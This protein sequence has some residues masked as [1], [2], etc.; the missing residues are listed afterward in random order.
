ML[1]F[2]ALQLSPDRDPLDP[3]AD[4]S[5]DL[6][7]RSPNAARTEAESS[8]NVN[9]RSLSASGW[10]RNLPQKLLDQPPRI[11]ARSPVERAAL[12]YLHANCGHCHG[13]SSDS[14]GAVPVEMLLAQDVTD[15]DS[16]NKV[17][18]SLIGKQS[19]FRMAAADGT[20]SQ[21]AMPLVSP[22]ESH[23]SLLPIRMQSRDPRVQMPPLGTSVIDTEAL[24]LIEHWI[25]QDLQPLRES[26]P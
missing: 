19:R 13:K 20:V 15:P 22:G 16:T 23:S 9:L 25:N 26:Q 5:I 4:A 2:S 6:G 7:S 14:G 11:A 18:R 17:L 12:G 8:R 10:L 1:G 21:G 24:A 3:H